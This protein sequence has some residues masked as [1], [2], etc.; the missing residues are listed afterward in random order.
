MF[1][2]IQIDAASRQRTGRQLMLDADTRQAAID[3]LLAQL[4]LST[5][6]AHVDPSRTIVEVD[7]Y[8]WTLV[9]ASSKTQSVD[10]PSLRRAGAK[11]KRVR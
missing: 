10:N 4:E 11:H 3:M 1:K 9:P 2:A 5:E 7:H 6:A 8:L